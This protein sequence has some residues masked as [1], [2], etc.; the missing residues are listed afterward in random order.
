MNLAQ[1]SKTVVLDHGRVLAIPQDHPE[2]TVTVTAMICVETKTRMNCAE[3]GNGIIGGKETRIWTKTRIETVRRSW[4]I[5][6]DGG[7]MDGGTSGWLLGAIVVGTGLLT[8]LAV[9]SLIDG[10]S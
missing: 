8:R 6:V 1:G 2:G 5:P 3:T 7:M 4:M 10:Q 9:M